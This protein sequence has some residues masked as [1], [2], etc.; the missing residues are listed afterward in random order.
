V[1]V[2]NALQALRAQVERSTADID[3]FGARE[4][5]DLVLDWYA[6]ER[7]VDAYPLTES[8]DGVLIQW[9]AYDFGVP[10]SFQFDVTRQ[11]TTAEGWWAR[12][13][14]IRSEDVAL[15]QVRLTLHYGVE[16]ATEGVEGNLWIFDPA[17]ADAARAHVI[18]RGILDLLD[19][20]QPLRVETAF[21]QA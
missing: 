18:E 21:D 11:F 8:G 4:A 13:L 7:F 19:G 16:A 15:W 1:K 20:R 12:L 2:R 3:A 17:E 5:M 10:A 14:R 9:G 6:S